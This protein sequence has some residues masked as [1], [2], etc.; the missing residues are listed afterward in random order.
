MKR[1]YRAVFAVS[2]VV[3][4]ACGSSK[5]GESASPTTV[6]VPMAEPAPSATGVATA[7]PSNDPN[8]PP[9]VAATPPPA[10]L[11]AALTCDAG[12]GPSIKPATRD[13]TPP[14]VAGQMTEQAAQAKRLFDAEKWKDALNAMQRVANGDTGDD[15]G[16]KQLA[17]YHAA[18]VLFRMKR[19]AD[20][21]QA[22]ATIAKKSNHMKHGETILWLSKIADAHPELVVLG[23]FATY[24]PEDVARFN[25]PNQL[26]VYESLSYFLGRER[27]AEGKAAEGRTLLAHVP[28]THPY[29]A[30]AKKCIVMK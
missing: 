2:T 25:N 23:D 9:P 20:S 12:P 4:F 30:A 22:F 3:L 5:P 14:P 19:E 29:F 7:A 10:P 26:V 15:D 17:E 11:P 16:N 27:I 13:K 8:A 21:Y 24:T 28:D 18:I 6:N 1:R